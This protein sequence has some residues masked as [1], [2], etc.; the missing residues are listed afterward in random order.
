MQTGRGDW[1]IEWDV[2][3]FL[4][5]ATC[6]QLQ[7]SVQRGPGLHGELLADP[8]PG[9]TDD[10]GI[11]GGLQALWGTES[12]PVPEVPCYFPLQRQITL[13]HT[14]PWVLPV[15]PSTVF[16]QWVVGHVL[17]GPASCN[18][19]VQKQPLGRQ[20]L[21]LKDYQLVLLPNTPSF[22][23]HPE[24]TSSPRPLEEIILLCPSINKQVMSACHSFLPPGKI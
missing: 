8:S 24:R 9:V 19:R 11:C 5:T 6:I 14:G 7:A 22:R 17:E 1:L 21:P 4:R 3:H 15:A 20:L 2:S 10:C 13:P 18:S 12:Q 16:F 23:A